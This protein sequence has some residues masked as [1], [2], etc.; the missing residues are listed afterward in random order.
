MMST[1]ACK[2]GAT[3]TRPSAMAAASMPAMR[4]AT[5]SARST[6]TRPRAS[7]RCYAHGCGRTVASRRRSCQPISASS[8]SSTTPVAGA[9]RSSAPSSPAWSPRPMLATPKPDKSLNLF[10]GQRSNQLAE[11]GPEVDPESRHQRRRYHT[12]ARSVQLDI[13]FR[14]GLAADLD[15]TADEVDDPRLGHTVPGVEGELGTSVVG[16]RTV[17]DL[18]Q[19][20]HVGDSRVARTIEVRA[21][22][23]E[24]QVG[25]RFVAAVEPEGALDTHM[26]LTVGERARDGAAQE[27]CDAVVLAADR[28]HVDDLP[29]DQLDAILGA[30]YSGRGHVVVVVD[31]EPV[32]FRRGRPVGG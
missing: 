12:V 5:G 1:P 4:M 29:L 2:T 30:E 28:G 24:H 21:R 19:Q 6:S 20:Q 11:Q 18:D 16:E 22:A 27:I 13:A 15:G 9:R 14:T 7:G 26:H 3:G 10:R 32:R 17:G 8:S 31:V 23:Q 25:L